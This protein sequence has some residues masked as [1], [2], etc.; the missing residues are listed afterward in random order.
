MR[1]TMGISAGSDVICSALLTTT[2]D[3]V[4]T[5]DYRTVTADGA[6][7]DVGDLVASSIDMVERTHHDDIDAVAVAYRSEQHAD[8]I[9]LA[10]RHH[11]ITLVPELSAALTYLRHTGEVARYTNVVVADVGASGTSVAVVDQIDGTVHAAERTQDVGGDAFDRRLLDI[12]VSKAQSPVD[13]AKSDRGIVTA[14]LRTAKEHL[15][16]ADTVTVDHVS[17]EAVTVTRAEFTTA[18][19]SELVALRAFLRA[20]VDASGHTPCAV[21]LIGGGAHV[22]AVVD[23]ASDVLGLPIVRT[24]EPDAVLAKGAALLVRSSP[25]G[26]FPVHRSI[27]RPRAGSLLRTLGVLAAG[28]TVAAFV[29]AYGVQ[30]VMPSDDTAVSP[31]ATVSPE[32]GDAPAP[33]TSTLAP[34]NPS[35]FGTTNLEPSSSGS[36][37]WV[38]TAAAEYPVTAAPVNDTTAPATTTPSLRPAPGLPS[39]VL[40]PWLTDVTG[41]STRAPGIQTAPSTPPDISATTPAPSTTPVP[42]TTEPPVVTTSPETPATTPGATLVSPVPQSTA[43][44]TS[45]SGTETTT[46]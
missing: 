30:A 21:A 35:D 45:P 10:A 27:S 19:E 32:Q 41:L 13:T 43:A 6:H 36:D 33:R 11:D 7:T 4:D 39:I 20:V 14:R 24:G 37:T 22:P 40:P 28:L 38:P 15:S 42:T 1:T 9:R 3:G 12:V 17:D 2:P 26:E 34:P 46:R 29:M 44:A 31:A 18:I 23:A 25:T 16:S 5:F 8:A